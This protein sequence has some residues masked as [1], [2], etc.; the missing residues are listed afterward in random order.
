MNEIVSILYFGLLIFGAGPRIFGW[1]ME[2]DDDDFLTEDDEYRFAYYVLSA[3]AWLAIVHALLLHIPFVRNADWTLLLI[4]ACTAGVAVG[5]EIV[6]YRLAK[7]IGDSRRSRNLFSHINLFSKLLFATV[8][9]Y[10]LPS[11]DETIHQ[12]AV[13][14]NYGVCAVAFI[15]CFLR[16]LFWPYARVNFAISAVAFVLPIVYWPFPE[17]WPAARCIAVAGMLAL[18]PLPLLWRL[19]GGDFLD[20]KPR[21]TLSGH[22]RFALLAAGLI[23][24]TL[25]GSALLVIKL[26]QDPRDG[27]I[28]WIMAGVPTMLS[29]WMT[30]WLLPETIRSARICAR[31]R[32]H[33]R[34]LATSIVCNFG[35]SLAQKEF[36]L[37]ADGC[38]STL[39]PAM[40]TRLIAHDLFGVAAYLYDQLRH[41]PDALA[42]YLT[43]AFLVRKQAHKLRTVVFNQHFDA[44]F[45]PLLLKGPSE[46]E[47]KAMLEYIYEGIPLPEGIRIE[48]KRE[49]F[50][51]F[52]TLYA[53]SGKG[54]RG[55]ADRFFS[56]LFQAGRPQSCDLPGMAMLGCLTAD[57]KIVCPDDLRRIGELIPAESVADAFIATTFL[58][59]FNFN[60]ALTGL[61]I[62]PANDAVAHD[63]KVFLASLIVPDKGVTD[64]KW[65][66]WV[67][68]IAGVQTAPD[69]SYSL[70]IKAW[71][72]ALDEKTTPGD[73]TR[74]A[75]LRMA[76]GSASP[77]ADQLLEAITSFDGAKNLL[78]VVASLPATHTFRLGLESAV[79]LVRSEP[80][81][82]RYRAQKVNGISL[83]TMIV[84]G[85]TTLTNRSIQE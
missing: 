33:Q 6:L 83:E 60:N 32:R 28:A 22:R 80:V 67:R 56:V 64:D 51:S 38:L 74:A 4:I 7:T 48:R 75:W 73:L 20:R 40:L 49:V 12:R 44:A 53:E 26:A 18:L 30:A 58:L 63:L 14:I 31:I 25:T 61:A 62:S 84:A 42:R 34:I 11:L 2:C 9:V 81:C 10:A 8:M 70:N 55:A 36:D 24:L 50:E 76:Q 52:R 39:S 71:V 57:G 37:D 46:K 13:I 21:D 41:P 54:I 43:E 77:D 35:V 59:P 27:R 1:I 85:W 17:N 82:F 66:G 69:F 65:R 3:Y 15:L 47:R 68:Y 23:L 19:L 5:A 78:Q 72:K 79:A 45:L 29:L 16:M